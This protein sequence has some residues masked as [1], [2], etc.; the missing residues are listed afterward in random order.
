ML[1][2]SGAVYATLHKMYVLLPPPNSYSKIASCSSDGHLAYGSK[3]VIVLIRPL[4]KNQAI[5]F[6]CLE[7]NKRVVNVSF[8]DATQTE[9]K[10]YLASAGIDG[11]VTIWNVH[12]K[13]ECFKHS[14]H[15]STTYCILL[16]TGQSPITILLFFCAVYVQFLLSCNW[17]SG[18]ISAVII[19]I[20]FIV[21]V[22]AYFT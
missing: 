2:L 3:S 10:F 21:F 13:S 16:I 15:V 4:Q 12:T 20:F 5:D 9:A 17:Y 8:S 1:L 6:D 19:Y 14:E 18:C 7:C 11:S 22:I